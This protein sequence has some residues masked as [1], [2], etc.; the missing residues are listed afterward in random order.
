[1]GAGAEK[2]NPSI[3]DKLSA[4]GTLLRATVKHPEGVID[5]FKRGETPMAASID[6]AANCNLRCQHCYLYEKGH[7]EEGIDDPNEFLAKVREMRDQNPGIVHVTWV[8]GEPMWRKEVLR[9]TV[10]IFPTNWVITNGTIPVDGEWQNTAFFIS[11]DGTE[12]I[13][14]QIRQPWK[15]AKRGLQ[16]LP[17]VEEVPEQRRPGFNIYRRAKDTARTAT[18]PVYV[19]SVINK[20]NAGV[21]PELVDEW[22]KE[23]NV[24]GFAFSLHTPMIDQARESGMTENDERLF[25]SD[26]ERTKVV[27]MLLALKKQY[28]KFIAMSDGHKT[29]FPNDN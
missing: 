20:L 15:Q 23:G 6:I 8:G 12:T 11:I 9:E 1:M 10:K 5:M 13:H 25:L 3:R 29:I 7:Q 18:A 27:V 22:Y 2:F 24:R 19:H 21:I 26:E 17:L 4:A 28:G 16:A 14:N